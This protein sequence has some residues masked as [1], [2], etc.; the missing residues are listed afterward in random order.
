MIDYGHREEYWT[1]DEAGFVGPAD[2]PLDSSLFKN[3]YDWNRFLSPLAVS[4]RFRGD[5]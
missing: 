2:N 1:Q 3:L 5:C 4:T